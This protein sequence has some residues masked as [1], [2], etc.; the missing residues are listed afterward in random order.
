MPIPNGY[1]LSH[2]F[3]GELQ[4]EGISHISL[5]SVNARPQQPRSGKNNNK[6][7]IYSMQQVHDIH[8][9]HR[10]II[11]VAGSVRTPDRWRILLFSLHKSHDTRAWPLT[12][13]ERLEN[14]E[15]ILISPVT[16]P[17]AIYNYL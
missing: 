10:S 15:D 4:V 8:R 14:E 7:N 12:D 1:G 16:V 11:I 2:I 3:A 9:L 5:I 13:K 6:D 17:Q